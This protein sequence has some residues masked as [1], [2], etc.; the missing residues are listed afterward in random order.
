MFFFW[1]HQLFNRNKRRWGILDIVTACGIRL[2]YN[3]LHILRFFSL[4]Q[5]LVNHTQLVFR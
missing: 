3:I 2:L 4:L 5:N 1:E